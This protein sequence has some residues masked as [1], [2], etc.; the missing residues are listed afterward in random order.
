MP[1]FLESLPSLSIDGYLPQA[2]PSDLLLTAGNRLAREISTRFADTA[3]GGAALLPRIMPFDTWLRRSWQE[4]RFQAVLSGDETLRGATLL[5]ESQEE[6]LWE[7]T[8]RSAGA[9]EQTLFLDDTVQACLRS[10]ALMDEYRIPLD[11]PAWDRD[12]ESAVFRDWY[13]SVRAACRRGR[14]VRMARLAEFLAKRVEALPSLQGCRLILAGFEEPT[15]AQASLLEAAAAAAR[16]TLLLEPAAGAQT[17]PQAILRAA[18]AEVELRAAAAWARREL[19]ENPSGRIAVVV[20][21][22]AARRPLVMEVFDD[23]FLTEVFPSPDA[24]ADRPFHLSLGSRLA[25][26]PVARAL[27]AML[28]FL[29]GAGAVDDACALL[30]GPYFARAALE[31][32]ARARLETVLYRERREDVSLNR[33]HRAAIE[34]ETRA[35]LP[36]AH[37]KNA[38]AAMEEFDAAE[39][40]APSLWAAQLRA[41]CVRCLWLG[42]PSLS[43]AEFQTR[44]R[45]LEELGALAELDVIR[46]RMEFRVFERV[47]RRRLEAATFQPESSPKPV[48]VAGLF[49]V[50]GLRFDSVWVCG[51]TDDVLPRPLQPDPFLP[52]SLQRSRGLPRCDSLREREFAGRSFARML[53]LA[54]RIVLS[55]HAREEQETLEPSPLLRALAARQEIEIAAVEGAPADAPLPP[56]TVEEMKDWRSGALPVAEKRVQRGSQVLADQAACPFRAFA[57]TRLGSDAELP[58]LP[59]MNRMDQGMFA[60]RALELFWKE[61]RSLEGLLALGADA[62]AGRIGDCVRE[63]L[64]EFPAGQG[65]VLA[66]AQLE[67]E[68]LRLSQLLGNWLEL[69]KQRQPFTILETERRQTVDLGSIEL[70]IRPDRVDQLADHSL[71]LIDYKTGRAK[72]SMWDGD[73]PEQPQ[74]LLYLAAVQA[75]SAIAFGCLKA[76]ETGWEVYGDDVPGRFAGNKRKGEPEGGWIDFVRRSREAVDRLTREFRDGFAA[77]DPLKGEDTCKYCEQK[78]FCRIGEAAHIRAGA[79][80]EEGGD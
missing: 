65:D 13:G 78:P 18:D 34:V 40:F 58:Q 14:F 77:V 16:E 39:D 57:R 63:A 74:L 30:R 55:Y 10:G 53:R 35:G 12:T 9:G 24:L 51:L 37:L 80:D 60:H 72:R 71:A 27:L 31:R 47:L 26:T 23:A 21:D 67:A 73:R 69:E 41:L 68:F 32:D 62:L 5:S 33:L 36:L 17:V 11:N 46:S 44:Q 43:S 76:G 66:D 19:E 6:M 42:D 64:A 8:L 56:A 50:T 22:L 49:E 54:P 3:A 20:P 45:V 15:P 70:R 2:S 4:L 7:Q 48:L 29:R 38:L 59:L 25:A 28:P 75:V 52:R 61:T 1:D 79:G